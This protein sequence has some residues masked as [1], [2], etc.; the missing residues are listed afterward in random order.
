M[1]TIATDGKSM[2]G[3]SQT[4]GGNILCRH[5]PKVFK[6]KDGRVFGCC[7]PVV[8]C[9]KFEAWMASSGES[10]KLSE[11][12][13]ALVLALDGS[14]DWIDR[15]LIAVRHIVPFAIGSGAEIAIGALLAGKSPAEAVKIAAQRDVKTGG[16]VNFEAIT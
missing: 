8:D 3:D 7:G 9:L 13:E 4:T 6:A 10:P 1:T 11:G 15:E 5:A 14:V 16:E 2:A 12:F